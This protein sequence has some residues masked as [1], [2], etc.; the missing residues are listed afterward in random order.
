LNWRSHK[1]TE[2]QVPEIQFQPKLY[3]SITRH[4]NVA[5]NLIIKTYGGVEIYL[6]VFLISELN[7]R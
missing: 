5:Q 7:A 4:L 1:V 3:P 6:N 2:M